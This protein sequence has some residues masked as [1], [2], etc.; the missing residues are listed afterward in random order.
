MTD[1]VVTRHESRDPWCY[2][3][4]VDG[5][6]EVLHL[7]NDSTETARHEEVLAG[8]RTGLGAALRQHHA[9]QLEALTARFSDTTDPDRRSAIEFALAHLASFDEPVSP[10]ADWFPTQADGRDPSGQLHIS[11]AGSDVVVLEAPTH[12]FSDRRSAAEALLEALNL[13]LSRLERDLLAHID[14]SPEP[15][16]DPEPEP[17]PTWAELSARADRYR[18]AR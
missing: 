2:V 13:A 3:E 5:V 17:E 12:L 11:V 4:L 10:S 15:R 7:R 1:P 6:V 9:D 14:R 16:P 18:F 8:L